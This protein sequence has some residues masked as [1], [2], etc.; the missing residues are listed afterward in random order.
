MLWS[1]RGTNSSD[2]TRTRAG[3]GYVNTATSI[4]P[5][6]GTNAIGS[7]ATFPN[8]EFVSRLLVNHPTAGAQFTAWPASGGSVNGAA[9]TQN[10][11]GQF[12]RG[13]FVDCAPGKGTVMGTWVYVL[14]IKLT[15]LH[16]IFKGL[17]LMANL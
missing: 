4:A 2:K 8:D 3:D 12:G 13:A 5:V 17:D 6:I 15:D 1:S 11:A 7:G 10:L 9:I 16:P 14:K